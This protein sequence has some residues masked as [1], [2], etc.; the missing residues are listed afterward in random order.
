MNN[1]F[2]PRVIAAAVLI[3]VLIPT[4]A[5]AHCD[6]L[7]GPVVLAA[8]R[9]LETDNVKLVLPWVE[10]D[11]EAEVT[12]AFEQARDVRKL[13]DQAKG[14][15]DRYF[16]ETLVRIH[17]AGEGEP[18]TGLKPAGRDLGPAIPA[19]DKAIE[20]GSAKAVIE[21]ITSKVEH[22]VQQRFAEAIEAKAKAADPNDVEAGRRFVRAYVP[23]LH[24]VERVY[25][26]VAGPAGGHD[27]HAAPVAE[28]HQAH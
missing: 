8:Q 2:A 3:A 6:S 25:D 15:A 21:L 16:F 22:G 19:A 4:S 28:R 20:I 23:F 5:W 24:Y 13:N 14:L 18:Y 10:K 11:A 17:R 12:A 9:A 1:R 26:A 27:S 7:D